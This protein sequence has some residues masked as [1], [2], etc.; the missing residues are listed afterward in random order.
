MKEKTEKA[1]EQ[2]PSQILAKEA[3]DLHERREKLNAEID[4]LSKEI[5][6]IDARIGNILS[7]VVACL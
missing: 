7:D 2:K 6:Q 3:K 1:G 4:A 5:D